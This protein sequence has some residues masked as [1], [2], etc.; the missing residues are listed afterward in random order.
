MMQRGFTIQKDEVVAAGA[1]T[2]NILQ[3]TRLNPVIANGFI[4]V[5]LTCSVDTLTA[6]L[7]IQSDN[8]FQSLKIQDT[9]TG[10]IRNNEDWVVLDLPVSKADVVEL[11]FTSADAGAQTVHYKVQYKPYRGQRR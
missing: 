9:G 6:S 11:M 1:T 3:G 5:W 4:S 7:Q 10:Y 2:T 8:I